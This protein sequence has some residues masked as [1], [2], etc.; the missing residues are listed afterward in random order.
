MLQNVVL[1]HKMEFSYVWA[2]I[3]FVYRKSGEFFTPY[4]LF[5]HFLRQQTNE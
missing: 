2:N 3:N 4:I 1:L 5:H